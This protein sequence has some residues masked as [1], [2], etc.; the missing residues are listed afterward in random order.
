M[1]ALFV[2]VWPRLFGGGW[3][4]NSNE[5]K[6]QEFKPRALRLFRSAFTPVPFSLLNGC[7]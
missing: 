6:P 7:A 2:N 5:L 1:G 4:G 3:V